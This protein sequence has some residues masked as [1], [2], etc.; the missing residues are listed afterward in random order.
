[1]FDYNTIII[2]GPSQSGNVSGYGGTL[3]EQDLVYY[4][5]S[6]AHQASRNRPRHP[7]SAPFSDTGFPISSNNPMNAFSARQPNQSQP[8]SYGSEVSQEFLIHE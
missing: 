1:M 4:P 2:L 3:P 7:G 8:V 5:D 6:R